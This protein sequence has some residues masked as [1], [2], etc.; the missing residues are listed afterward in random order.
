[1]IQDEPALAAEGYCSEYRRC[2]QGLKPLLFHG[3]MDGLKAVHSKAIRSHPLFAAGSASS[4]PYCIDPIRV[5]NKKAIQ[6]DGLFAALEQKP[7]YHPGAA[8]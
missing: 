7:N 6:P 2:P 3:F 1:M 8:E 5:S 4:F